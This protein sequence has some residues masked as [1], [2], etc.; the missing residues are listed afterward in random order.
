MFSILG[1]GGLTT[2]FFLTRFGGRFLTLF[3]F[4]GLLEPKG[5]F[6][7]GGRRPLNIG[8]EITMLNGV[9]HLSFLFGRL[10]M[11]WC[12]QISFALLFTNIRDALFDVFGRIR[13]RLGLFERFYRQIIK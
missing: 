11:C 13:I 10:R 3:F 5:L 6:F 8:I 1:W 9:Q 7:A 2:L 12:R 4:P